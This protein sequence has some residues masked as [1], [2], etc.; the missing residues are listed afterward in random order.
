M[1]RQHREPPPPPQ[2]RLD[3]VR[4]AGVASPIVQGATYC[5]GETTWG[6]DLPEYVR[7]FN[8]SLKSVSY[9]RYPDVNNGSAS[10][11]R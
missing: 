11:A 3:A 8:A 6:R 2:D 7:R 4:D 10:V 9:H 5:S 1:P